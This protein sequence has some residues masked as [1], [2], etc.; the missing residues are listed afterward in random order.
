MRNAYI[1]FV[2]KP[3]GKRQVRRH[4]NRCKNNNKMD[5]KEWGAKMWS[6]FIWLRT[7]WMVGS[8]EHINEPLDSIKD[9]VFLDLLSISFSKSTL[10]HEVG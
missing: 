4:A 5:W 9:G 2:R 6:G 7:G 8:C 10:H 3:E 1:V